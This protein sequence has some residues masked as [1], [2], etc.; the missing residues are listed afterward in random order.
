[1][2]IIWRICFYSLVKLHINNVL[3]NLSFVVTVGVN[4]WLRIRLLILEFN[5]Q[6]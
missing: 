2:P 5:H 4:G 1:M 3:F 6:D